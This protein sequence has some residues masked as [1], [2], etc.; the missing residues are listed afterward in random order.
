MGQLVQGVWSDSDE[1][2]TDAGGAYVR[3]SSAFRH[4]VTADGSAGPTGKAGFRAEPGRYHLFVAHTCPWAHRAAIYRKLKGL[5]GMVTLSQADA[6]KSSGWS[7]TQGFEHLAPGDDGIFHLHQVYTAA[8]P[9]YSGK[10]TVPTLWDRERRTIVNNESSEIIRMLNSAFD[11]VGASAENLCPPDLLAEIDA[12]NGFVYEHVNNGVYRAGFA[13]T[14]AAYEEAVA[15]V[16]KGLD[17]MEARLG[18]KRYLAGD[19]ITEADWRA[20]PTLLR[21]DLVYF[22]HFKCNVRRVQDYPHLSAYTRE[23]FQWPGIADTCDLEATKA[24]YYLSMPSLNPPGIVPAGPDMGWLN[25]A[26][27]RG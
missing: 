13:K 20:F 5:E 6:P 12:V 4:W 11:G 18:E 15:K 24:G 17:W 1:R 25:E 7:F 16:F 26:H 3:A 8:D 27:G 10:V 9:S 14:Q 23:L 19:R 21:F 22:S 2:P